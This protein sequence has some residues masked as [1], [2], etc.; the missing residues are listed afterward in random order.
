MLREAVKPKMLLAGV[1]VSLLLSVSAADVW[2]STTVG[3]SQSYRDAGVAFPSTPSY[4]AAEDVFNSVNWGPLKISTVRAVVP[5]DLAY[6]PA[7]DHRRLEFEN[8][9]RR[10]QEV[11][12]VAYVV[13]G[14][15]ELGPHS[16]VNSSQY[17]L[18]SDGSAYVA[19]FSG[20]YTQAVERFLQSYGP[21]TSW[22]VRLLGAWNEPNEA[23][24]S[25][26]PG[27]PTNAAVYLPTSSGY[28]ASAKLSDHPGSSCPAGSSTSTCGPLLAGYYWLDARNAMKV[29]CP[30]NVDPQGNACAVV[31]GEFNSSYDD[32]NYW[33]PYA[34]AIAS[35]GSNRPQW[36]SF[37][38]WH[39]ARAG[40]ECSVSATSKCITRNFRIWQTGLG[41]QWASAQTWDTEAGA[42]YTSDADQKQRV[43]Q[44]LSL[45]SEFS[46]ARLYYYNFQNRGGTDSGLV[47]AGKVNSEINTR[48]RPAWEVIKCR[49]GLC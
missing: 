24:V 2:A 41:G 49:N 1:L 4:S 3:I 33:N 30:E 13:L 5:F 48:A 45:S 26:N 35:L 25:V 27:G 14:P 44:L 10:T 21:N 36:L 23:T 15:S 17:S 20:T 38:G 6:R 37:H 29:Q 22:D 31:G 12:L 42:D 9:L 43:Q 32:L 39:D 47:D 7:E 28:S 8:W 19:P 18:T 46:V 16:I 11:G 34:N 40:T